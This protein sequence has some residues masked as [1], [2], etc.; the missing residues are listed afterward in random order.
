M[1]FLKYFVLFLLSSAALADAPPCYPWDSSAKNLEIVTIPESK[2]LLLVTDPSKAG[3]A[4]NWYCD[5]KYG[6]KRVAFVGWLSELDST[7]MAE[8][9][10]LSTAPKADRD[11]LWTAKIKCTNL[12]LNTPECLPYAPLRDLDQKLRAVTEPR[13]IVWQV[14]DNP[15]AVSRPVY[16]LAADGSRNLTALPNAKVSD[17]ATVCSCMARAIE[18][19][20]GTYCAV[21][22]NLNVA[23][24]DPT[25]TLP[26]SV[27][28]CIRIN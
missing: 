16:P 27:T 28:L 24:V 17:I 15:T 26:E 23:T 4:A 5:V 1:E 20:G 19:S 13:P 6:W 12:S 25:D 21:T 7:Y 9:R 18:E 11:A 22:G 14:K 10:V 8:T 3:F 2:A